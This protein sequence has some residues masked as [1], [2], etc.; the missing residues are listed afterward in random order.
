ML[1]FNNILSS[2]EGNLYTLTLGETTLL[3]ECGIPFQKITKYVDLTR[4]HTCLLTHSHMDHSRAVNHII[5]HIPVMTS[6]GTAE[7][8]NIQREYNF[9]PVASGRIYNINDDIR[10][11]PLQAY[12]NVP[13]PLMYHII[14]KKN[15]ILFAVDTKY[16]PCLIPG[17]THAY[18]EANHSEYYINDS[19]EKFTGYEHMELN[20]SLAF[21]NNHKF[22]L[23]E[24]DLLHVSKRFGDKELFMEIAK[25]R[26]GF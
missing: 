23:Q 24:Y 25:E 18:I 6:F 26:L 13:E 20:S 15:K 8:L 10:I 2:S 16:I 7:K 14:Y 21:L 3:L 17:L 11:Y 1:E 9:K 12:H 4:I 22:S 19:E 5:K